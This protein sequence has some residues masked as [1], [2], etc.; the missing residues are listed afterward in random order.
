MRCLFDV[1]DIRRE[2][3]KRL[4]IRVDDLLLPTVQWAQSHAIHAS[5]MHDE[6]NRGY[7]AACAEVLHQ[8]KNLPHGK[9]VD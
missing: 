5:D 4:K 7:G 6:Y 8:L 2:F 1:D 9:G 3:D